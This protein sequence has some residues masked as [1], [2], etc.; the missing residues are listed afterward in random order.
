MI[1]AMYT[2]VEPS[3][4]S[5]SPQKDATF[6]VLKSHILDLLCTSLIVE[7]TANNARYLLHL[8]TAFVVEDVAF[9]PGL[10]ALVIK[11]IQERMLVIGQWPPM[12]VLC[13]LQTFN[14]INALWEYVRRDNKS[15]SRELVIALCR[16]IDGLL[17]SDNLVGN[18]HLIV[19]A[20]DCMTRWVLLGDWIF[21]DRDCHNAVISTLCRGIGVLSRDDDFAAITNSVGNVAVVPSTSGMSPS[22]THV[23]IKDTSDHGGGLPN[24][25]VI[26]SGFATIHGSSSDKKKGTR[27]GPA[28][29]FITK[30]RPPATISGAAGVSTGTKDAGL[31]LPTFATLSAELAIKTAAETAMAQFLNHLGN[32]PP[33]G[34]VTGVSHLS[35]LWNEEREVRRIGGVKQK[36]KSI[37]RDGSFLSEQSAADAPPNFAEYKKYLKYFA[38]DNRVIIGMVEIPQ[39]AVE[40]DGWE[41]G[42][43]SGGT[44]PAAFPRQRTPQVVIVLRDGTGKYTWMSTLEYSDDDKHNP[45]TT[46]SNITTTLLSAFTTEHHHFTPP[47]MPY[48]PSGATVVHQ[49]CVNESSIP[50]LEKLVEAGTDS[51]RA[52]EIVRKLTERQVEKEEKR[53][54][55]IKKS[56]QVFRM[57]LAHSGYLTLENRSKLVPLVLSNALLKDLDKLDSLPE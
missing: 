35:S 27:S 39:W 1:R 45:T 6:V 57:L 46:N 17:M 19:R 51:A 44:P 33:F 34:E 53:V 16:Y 38:F 37:D 43:V 32:F 15:C 18:Q 10:P 55:E 40:T 20:Y 54:E 42:N 8:L 13:A 21:T 14:D 49:T 30:I 47:Q 9:C 50:P 3:S 41:E 31:G 12:V 56:P 23:N 11:T 29:K 28:S 48:S 25:T 22:A 52:Y 36:L 4:S 2:K 7:T 24:A 5:S 26:S